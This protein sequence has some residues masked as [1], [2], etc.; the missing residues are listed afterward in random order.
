[1][2]PMPNEAQNTKFSREKRSF[3]VKRVWG[4]KNLAIILIQLRF[5]WEQR[6]DCISNSSSS[7]DNSNSTKLWTHV[8]SKL[9]WKKG[10]NRG[11]PVCCCITKRSHSGF[12]LSSLCRY[13]YMI[14]KKSR[15]ATMRIT[16]PQILAISLD[17]T[18]CNSIFKVL[19]WIH[20]MDM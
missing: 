11:L 10:N 18:I 14:M 13:D 2:K 1:M 6:I 20:G 5:V 9:R 19:M 15:E 17:L 7:F 8:I 16:P 12:W 4:S 3:L